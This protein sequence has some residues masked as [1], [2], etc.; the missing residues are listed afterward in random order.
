M[1]A[2]TKAKDGYALHQES[3]QIDGMEAAI[4]VMQRVLMLNGVSADAVASVSDPVSILQDVM[5]GV[6]STGKNAFPARPLPKQV[7]LEDVVPSSKQLE[8]GKFSWHNATNGYSYTLIWQTAK[9]RDIR[10]KK[11]RGSYDIMALNGGAKTQSLAHCFTAMSNECADRSTPLVVFMAPSDASSSYGSN[12]MSTQNTLAAMISANV[13]NI[14]FV[15]FGETHVDWT[16][17]RAR[18]LHFHP[19]TLAMLRSARIEAPQLNIGYVAGDAPSW[20]ADP[21]PLI[22]SLFDTLEQDEN[23]LIFK[24]GEAYAPLLVHRPQDDLVT[25]VKPRKK[26]SGARFG[27]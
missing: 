9:D 15:Q 19:V 16:D 18:Q 5:S 17:N 14:S 20:I 26:T 25:Y 12:I 6:Y 27:G 21:A 13:K 23:E 11:P 1:A 3:G 7:K 4:R 10:G 22:E 24:R 2:L 8:R